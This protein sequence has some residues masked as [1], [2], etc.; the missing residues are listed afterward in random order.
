MP[1]EGQ[2]H[3]VGTQS[4]CWEGRAGICVP[5]PHSLRYSLDI[6]RCP[7]QLCSSDLVGVFSVLCLSV[8]VLG[9]LVTVYQLLGF[10]LGFS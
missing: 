2:A 5:G 3:G 4:S 6:K 7:L 10:W 8:L 9:P 1:A